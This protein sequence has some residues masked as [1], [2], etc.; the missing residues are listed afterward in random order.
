MPS[1]N[2]KSN[3]NYFV[4]LSEWQ[5]LIGPLF[6]ELKILTMR[7]M[8]SYVQLL[9]FAV[10]WS[11]CTHQLQIVTI[12]LQTLGAEGSILELLSHDPVFK[13]W[14][15]LQMVAV[16]WWLYNSDI[17]TANQDSP[18]RWKKYFSF[19]KLKSSRKN[20]LPNFAPKKAIHW[21]LGQTTYM[22]V[23]RHLVEEVYLLISIMHFSMSD[24]VKIKIYS[25]LAEKDFPI[26][27]KLF[28][29]D[30][31]LVEEVNKLISI[32]QVVF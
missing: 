27:R 1:F 16:L 19:W 12:E 10:L 24:K 26:S 30:R 4:F 2:S 32:I 9:R 22:L 23:E 15:W 20:F 29:I 11:R 25:Y 17:K 28:L 3:L 13:L 6:R 18:H 31:N 8:W 14:I 21:A 5:N 7:Q